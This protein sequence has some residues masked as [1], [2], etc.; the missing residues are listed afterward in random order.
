MGFSFG[1]E[2]LMQICLDFETKS[3]S[4]L[5]TSKREIKSFWIPNVVIEFQ[6]WSFKAQSSYNLI[7]SSK[8]T[9]MGVVDFIWVIEVDVLNHSSNPTMFLR[10]GRSTKCT[11]RHIEQVWVNTQQRNIIFFWHVASSHHVQRVCISPI[12]YLIYIKRLWTIIGFV[13]G[14]HRDQ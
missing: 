10:H 2:L 3:I 11:W 9:V 14:F 12:L 4:V 13:M 1:S 7:S 5:R 6:M 8:I